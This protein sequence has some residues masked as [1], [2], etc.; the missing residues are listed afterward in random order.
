MLNMLLRKSDR[1]FGD[2]PI[3][4]LKTTLY[5]VRKRLAAKLQNPRLLRMSFHTLR[6]WKATMEYH[7][8]KAI[9]YVKR[10]LGHREVRNTEIYITVEEKLFNTNSDQSTLQPQK[11]LK[12][13][14]SSSKWALN[15][16][17]TTTE[18]Y[19]SE[20]KKIGCKT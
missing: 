16:Y 5:N 15:I 10:L 3:N 17:A 13:Q 11:P 1:V 20:K 8:T 19:S 9:L 4:S 12:K 6:Y 2:G 7:R 18:S 14:V